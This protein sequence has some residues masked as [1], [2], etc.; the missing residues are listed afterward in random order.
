MVTLLRGAGGHL[1]L[2]PSSRY[3]WAEGSVGGTAAGEESWLGAWPLPCLSGG[4]PVHKKESAE[5]EQ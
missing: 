5:Q 3:G 4:I 1:V 2:A